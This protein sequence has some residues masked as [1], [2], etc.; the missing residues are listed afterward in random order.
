MQ[1]PFTQ[2]LNEAMLRA[3]DIRYLVTKD[4]GAAGGFGEKL[5]AARACGVT[6]LV[7]RRP[8][9]E[10]GIG[11]ED[12]LKLLGE[13]CGWT[14][15]RKKSHGRPRPLRKAGTKRCGGRGDRNHSAHLAQR[16]HG[17]GHVRRHGLL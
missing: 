6:P 15:D 8:L 11:V 16:T 7:I 2:A 3:L 17:G 10:E 5:R 12:C 1:G 4:T 14:A 13:R 9:Q